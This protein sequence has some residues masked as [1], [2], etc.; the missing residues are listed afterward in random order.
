[1]VLAFVITVAGLESSLLPGTQPSE[2]PID[3]H[4]AIATRRTI[5]VRMAILILYQTQ[6][7]SLF[8]LLSD[9]LNV[10]AAVS[11]GVQQRPISAHGHAVLFYLPVLDLRVEFNYVKMIIKKDLQPWLVSGVCVCRVS[12]SQP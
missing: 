5:L 9:A 1:V 6:A 7:L 8:A 12:L 10:F 11:P 2:G 4:T 3:R